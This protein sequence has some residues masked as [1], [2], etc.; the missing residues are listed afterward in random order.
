MAAGIRSH[1]AAA[2]LIVSLIYD[3]DLALAEQFWDWWRSRAGTPNLELSPFLETFKNRMEKRSPGSIEPN[4]L[5]GVVPGVPTTF[6]ADE[7][8]MDEDDIP[9]L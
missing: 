2:S 3:G 9:W 4:D 1:T 6:D 5:E 7:L 8:G